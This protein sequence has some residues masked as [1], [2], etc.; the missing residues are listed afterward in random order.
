[1]D[2]KKTFTQHEHQMMLNMCNLHVQNNNFRLDLNNNYGPS[3]TSDT[4]MYI[5]RM[6]RSKWLEIFSTSEELKDTAGQLNDLKFEK[7]QP[8]LLEPCKQLNTIFKMMMELFITNQQEKLFYVWEGL[9]KDG[10]HLKIKVPEDDP[11]KLNEVEMQILCNRYR[12]FTLV[13]QK[14]IDWYE[15]KPKKLITY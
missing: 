7:L 6:L 5:D 2:Y 8:P 15:L 9:W 11:S 1:M 13:C 3:C 12:V 14:M 4:D 10:P